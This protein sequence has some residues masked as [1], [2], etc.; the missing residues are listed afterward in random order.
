MSSLFRG[1]IPA[2]VIAETV[3]KRAS[4]KVTLCNGVEAPQ[5]IKVVTMHVVMK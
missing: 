5:K 2:S 4:M 3:R 1:G